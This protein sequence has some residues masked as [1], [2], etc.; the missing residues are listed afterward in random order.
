MEAGQSCTSPD[1]DGPRLGALFDSRRAGV[2]W[3]SYSFLALAALVTLLSMAVPAVERVMS[4][5]PPVEHSWQPFTAAFM[6][7]W[8]GF[9]AP[10][11]LA[12]NAFLIIECGRPCERLLGSPRFLGLSLAALGANAAFQSLVGGV[13]GSSLVIWAWG[14]PLFAALRIAPPTRIGPDSGARVRIRGVLII[15]YVVVTLLM[16]ATPY[17]GGWRGD[18]FRA[19]VLGN[20][21]HLVATAVGIAGTLI[22]LNAIRTRLRSFGR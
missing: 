11:H 7:G 8:P 16:G 18:P 17:I 20:Q 1:P 6:H 19:L 4:G 3:V 14:P 12:L 9:P 21:F 2:P 15:M 13:N 22:W 5:L 10:V